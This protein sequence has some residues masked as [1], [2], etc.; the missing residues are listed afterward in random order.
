[1]DT[2]SRWRLVRCLGAGGMGAVYLG[3]ESDGSEAVVKVIRNEFAADS[4][5]RVRFRR[6]VEACSRVRGPSAAELLEADVDGSPMW[7]AVRYVPG[8]RCRAAVADTYVLRMRRL[9]AVRTVSFM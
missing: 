9:V 6:E 5:F 2:A 4:A 1:M 3:Q 8:R 7:L